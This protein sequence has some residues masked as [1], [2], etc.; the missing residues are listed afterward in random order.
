VQLFFAPQDCLSHISDTAY[1]WQIAI[2][3]ARTELSSAKC[4]KNKIFTVVFFYT[5]V[6]DEPIFDDN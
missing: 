5:Q 2:F 6:I 4:L 1:A 3:P